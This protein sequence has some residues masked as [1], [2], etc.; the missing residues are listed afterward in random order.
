MAIGE[1]HVRDVS[2]VLPS[3]VVVRFLNPRTHVLI[4]DAEHIVAHLLPQS[5]AA[6]ATRVEVRVAEFCTRSLEISKL[7]ARLPRPSSHGIALSRKRQGRI[8]Q[9]SVECTG[10]EIYAPTFCHMFPNTRAD[11]PQRLS[12][13]CVS[14]CS[15]VFF[16]STLTLT[17][18]LTLISY[19]TCTLTQ[20]QQRRQ[21]RQ[22]RQYGNKKSA[23]LI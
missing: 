15:L 1:E 22:Q 11:V 7:I 17:L 9:R 21:R 18:N 16:A 14:L 20:Q 4:G 3:I 6:C 13:L 5:A 19:L 23:A 8:H 12:L 10:T 2:R